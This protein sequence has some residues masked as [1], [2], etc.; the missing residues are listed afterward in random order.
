MSLPHCPSHI[1][2]IW[3]QIAHYSYHESDQAM[4][5]FL[6]EMKRHLNARNVLW[7]GSGRGKD[8]SNTPV[9]E[10]LGEWTT[11]D[12]LYCQSSERP[13]TPEDNYQLYMEVKQ[14]HGIDPLTKAAIESAGSSRSFTRRDVI[15]DEEWQNHWIHREFH[16][17]NG[18]SE[19]MFVVYSV[20]S[21]C[22]SYIVFYRGIG[23]APFTVEER[24]FAFTASMGIGV[25]H[26]RMMQLRG[27]ALP[28]TRLL[29]PQEKAVLNLLIQGRR[30]KEVALSLGI[31]PT[32]VNKHLSSI[33]RKFGVSG[34]FDLIAQLM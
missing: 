16:Q 19:L 29:S 23:E 15:T 4:L 1:R 14:K 2:K 13:R 30:D 18:D 27:A 32:T 34:K 26:K 3:Q 33:Y 5:Y 11:V 9:I 20:D 28:S 17:K 6:E 10:M 12:V 24:E 31:S 7:I 25:L 21:A 22:E 8:A